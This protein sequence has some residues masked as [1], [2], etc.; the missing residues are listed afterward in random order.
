MY[1]VQARMEYLEAPDAESVRRRLSGYATGDHYLQHVF[2]QCHGTHLSAVFFLLA[3]DLAHAESAARELCLL[4]LYPEPAP[5][6][7]RL[8]S[9]TATCGPNLG[10]SWPGGPGAGD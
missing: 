5:P 4:D 1:F 6:R 2:M 3:P 9:C 10:P 8:L 7:G